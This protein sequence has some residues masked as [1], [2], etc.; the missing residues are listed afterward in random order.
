MA[1][2]GNCPNPE[3]K[4]LAEQVAR[5]TARGVWDKLQ[6]E[7]RKQV[8]SEAARPTAL[9]AGSDSLTSGMSNFLS[10]ALYQGTTKR[11]G[12]TRF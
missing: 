7:S 3:S 10:G 1:V 6:D 2:Q 12:I 11:G 4:A 8:C 9:G 5:E